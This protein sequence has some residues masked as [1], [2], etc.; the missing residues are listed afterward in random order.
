MVSGGTRFTVRRLLATIAV[1]SAI[2]G[3]GAAA[4]LGGAFFV[5]L[6]D[7]WYVSHECAPDPDPVCLPRI[8]RLERFDDRTS[9]AVSVLVTASVVGI[10][11]LFMIVR[12]RAD[13]EDP[14]RAA[15]DG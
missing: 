2:A 4:F 12:T 8:D 6:E 14:E 13:T 1:L 3:V 11:S 7:R 15:G 10:V 9:T 5:T